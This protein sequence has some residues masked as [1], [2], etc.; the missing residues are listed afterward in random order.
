M[1]SSASTFCTPPISASV[2]FVSSAASSFTSRQSGTGSARMILA[3]LTRPVH[4]DL[5]NL[6]SLADLDQLGKR[7]PAKPSRSQHCQRLN[8]RLISLFLNPNRDDFQPR[9]PRSLQRQHRKAVHYRRISPY[10]HLYCGAGLSACSRASLRSGSSL[11]N[12][13]LAVAINAS[14]SSTLIARR[15]PLPESAATACAVFSPARVS[16]LKSLMQSLNRP[17]LQKTRAVPTP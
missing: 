4:H 8:L 16:S 14:N 10:Q 5:G 2:F 3:C 1:P 7:L 17:S 6:L 11:D 15:R 9:L 12:S 13:A